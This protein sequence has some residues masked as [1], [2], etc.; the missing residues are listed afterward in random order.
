MRQNEI[1]KHPLF[2]AALAFAAFA[3]VLFLGTAGYMEIE[4][5]NFTDAV[6]MTVITLATVGFQEVHPL[7]YSGKWF[8]I[9]L[10]IINLSL[11][12]FFVSYITR[13]VLD[14]NFQVFYKRYKMKQS[15]NHLRDHVIICGFGRN[16]KAAAH[17][18]T[19]NNVPAV[20][21]EKEE[22]HADDEESL[23]FHVYA[24]ATKDETLLEAGIKNAKALITTLPDDANNLFI[25]LT[26]KELNPNL[27]II[28][29][30]SNDSSIRKLKSAGATEVIMPDKI[31]GIHM[32][33]VVINPD[34]NAFID[35]MA[36]QSSDVQI[37][38]I[39]VNKNIRLSEMDCWKKTGATILGIRNS[40]GNYILNPPAETQLNSGDRLIILGY[41]QQI[42][43]VEQ[44]VK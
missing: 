8:T 40:E 14:G 35:Y 32:A 5:F 19:R 41:E 25:V 11:I 33:N 38:E 16:G 34:V 27:I 4:H 18:I 12:T 23:R 39:G 10:I 1:R 24:D 15:I 43:I 17:L 13:Y 2:K 6:Y 7:S 37:S 22:Q 31:G 21:L 29:R 44:M 42:K 36:S 26:A 30:A 3:G 28:S 9:L 20:I